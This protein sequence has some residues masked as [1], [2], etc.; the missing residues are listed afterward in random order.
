MTP[1]NSYTN[2]GM[3]GT[4]QE[5]EA[6]AL[7]RAGL[8]LRACQQ[9]WDAPDRQQKLTEALEF[10]QKLWSIFQASLAEPD[11]P[12]PLALRTDI[13]RLGAFIDKRIFETMASPAAGKLTVIIDINFNLAA[14]LRAGAQRAQEATPSRGAESA[15]EEPMWA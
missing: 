13:L 9:N 5:I 4:D 10:N 1:Y 11:H 6:S 12:M 15:F 8:L 7:S 2:P 14:G 3:M